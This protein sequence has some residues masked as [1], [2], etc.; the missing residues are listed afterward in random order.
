MTEKVL[1]AKIQLAYD[2]TLITK[3]CTEQELCNRLDR[4]DNL[5]DELVELTEGKSGAFDTDPMGAL[6]FKSL[7]GKP[8]MGMTYNEM[9]EELGSFAFGE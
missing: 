9:A 3:G 2:A 6:D 7:T 5:V 8:F 4:Y 1:I